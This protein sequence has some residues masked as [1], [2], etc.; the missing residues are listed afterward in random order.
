MNSSN[1]L[2]FSKQNHLEIVND[3]FYKYLNKGKTYYENYC[4]R[5]FVVIIY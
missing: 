4:C 2:I 5:N 1:F 3:Y